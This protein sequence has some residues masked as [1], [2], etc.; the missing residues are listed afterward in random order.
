MLLHALIACVIVSVFLFL[1]MYVFLFTFISKVKLA[2]RL[3]SIIHMIKTSLF[4]S[5][6]HAFQY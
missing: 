6:R 4:I 1:E 3:E 2:A 5:V